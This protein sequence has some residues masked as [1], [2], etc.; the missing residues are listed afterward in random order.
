MAALQEEL[1]G[2]KKGALYKKSRGMDEADEADDPKEALIALI[3]AAPASST[4][5]SPAAPAGT[6]AEVARRS[7]GQLGGRS[8]ALDLE[9]VVELV[10]QCDEQTEAAKDADIVV[11]VGGSG[12][13]KSTTI[14]FL[15]GYQADGVMTPPV[16][17]Y[18]PTGGLV[19]CGIPASGYPYAP[20][21]GPSG[22]TLDVSHAIATS[23]MLRRAKSARVV[24]LIAGG[25]FGEQGEH[26]LSKLSLIARKCLPLPRVLAAL[27]V[28]F[29]PTRV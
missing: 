10:G 2:T 29:Q 24:L 16:Y 28:A 9:R 18:G 20:L 23:K 6:A 5:L 1:R 26:L 8:Y 15:L 19:F 21:D 27:F 4:D 25:H 22:L 11:I 17:A 13:G 3:V 12:V 7:H 14:N